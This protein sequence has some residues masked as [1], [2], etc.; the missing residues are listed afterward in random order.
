M[1]E[2]PKTAFELLARVPFKVSPLFAVTRPAETRP[3][4]CC[5]E[6]GKGGAGGA[7]YGP[8]EG[9]LPRSG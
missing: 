1:T 7:G 8:L 6:A 9:W 3:A 2:P 5:E 4:P